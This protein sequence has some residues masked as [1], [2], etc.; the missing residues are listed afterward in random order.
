MTGQKEVRI[1]DALE[2]VPRFTGFKFTRSARLV[3]QI[4]KAYPEVIGDV[5][6]FVAKYEAEN[7]TR[8]TPGIAKLKG[9]QLSAKDFG[10]QGFI[11]IPEPPTDREKL[12]AVLPKIIDH[13]EQPVTELLALLIAPNS[14]LA[15]HDEEGTVDSYLAEEAKK[16]MHRA[17]FDQL[18]ELAA[19]GA[20]VLVEQFS[21]RMDEAGNLFGL[22]GIEAPTFSPKTNENGASNPQSSIDSPGTTAGQDEKAFIASSGSS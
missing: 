10:E 13:A 1:G 19:V 14:K 17:E 21:S 16:L 2:V 7:A 20:T 4:A 15:E 5:Q 12:F 22:L 8:I 3:G 6:A 18:I 9:L 11:E